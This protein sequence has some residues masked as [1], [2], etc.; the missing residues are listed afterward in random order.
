[1]ETEGG[2]RETERKRTLNEVF[3][4]L[5]LPS[6][7]HLLYLVNVLYLSKQVFFIQT[8]RIPSLAMHFFVI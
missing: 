7:L 3:H 6:P 1:M 8:Y 4:Y 2:E 5:F